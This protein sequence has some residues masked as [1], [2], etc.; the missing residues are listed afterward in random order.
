MCTYKWL[1]PANTT[2]RVDYT[3]I[4]TH[5]RNPLRVRVETYEF[6]IF[7]PH[8]A[9]PAARRTGHALTAHR[10]FGLGVHK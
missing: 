7:I 4:F 6:F 8:P 3:H 9:I 2:E 10:P 5:D 1:A